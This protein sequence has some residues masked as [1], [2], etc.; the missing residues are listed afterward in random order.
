MSL[1]ELVEKELKKGRTLEF[2]YN[3]HTTIRLK[4]DKKTNTYYTESD[5]VSCI[6][7]GMPN[8]TLMDYSQDCYLAQ[9]I[10]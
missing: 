4:Y 2:R 1:N 10:D 7:D 3:N 5:D 6:V 8:I 9:F